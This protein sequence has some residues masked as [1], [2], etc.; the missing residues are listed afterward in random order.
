MPIH[1]ILFIQESL[2]KPPKAATSLSLSALE[3]YFLHSAY[4][5]TDHL[6]TTKYVPCHTNACASLLSLSVKT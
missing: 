3:I 5:T 6:D 2:F 1:G 4:S